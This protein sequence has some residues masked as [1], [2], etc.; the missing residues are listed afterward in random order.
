METTAEVPSV[1][2]SQNVEMIAQQLS[3]KVQ[4]NMQFLHTHHY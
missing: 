4:E 3:Y 1:K 2:G